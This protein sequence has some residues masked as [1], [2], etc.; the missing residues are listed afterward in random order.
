MAK[1]CARVVVGEHENARPLSDNL[2]KF[3]TD[4]LALLVNVLVEMEVG[5]LP[6]VKR[7][8]IEC[9]GANTLEQWIVS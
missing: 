4:L 3:R 8:A 7:Q 2:L 9:M 5:R 1:V 6:L